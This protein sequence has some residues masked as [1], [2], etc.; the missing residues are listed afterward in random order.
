M[1]PLYPTDQ[2]MFMAKRYW[3]THSPQQV[4]QEFMQHFPNALRIPSK[5]T[6]LYQSKK[7][8]DHGKVLNRHA[9]ASGRRKTART[10]ANIARVRRAIR[11]DPNLSSRRNPLPDLSQTTFNRIT[12]KDLNYHPYK[13]Q[14][15]HGL[16]PGDYAKR[17]TYSRW[18][19]NRPV[20]MLTD[21]LVVDEANFY[22]NGKVSTS[23]HRY[24]APKNA[25][26][27]GFVYDRRND[28]RKVTVWMGIMGN[29]RIIGPWFFQGNVNARAYLQV[30]DN[31]VVPDLIQH[32]G[33]QR[34]GAIRNVW[35]FQDGAPAHTARVIHARLQELFPNRV[36]GKGHPVP[37]PPRSPDL[38]P[39]DYFLWGYIQGEVYAPGPPASLQELRQRITGAVTALRRQRGM[40]RRAVQSMRDRAQTCINLGGAQVEGRAGH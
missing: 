4:R 16:E 10:D 26:P 30:I 5:N 38:T 9:D 33:Q 27:R 28:R 20:R 36:V 6:I 13:I 15:R 11:H 19:L 17:M 18:L 29:N 23:H 22:L 7:F 2:R 31:Q 25:P 34:N 32:Y 35:F 24:Y 1:A 3:E 14:V 37:W 21:T 40:T 39:C 8:V 12:R